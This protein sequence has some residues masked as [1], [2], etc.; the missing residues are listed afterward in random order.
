[1]SSKILIAALL[2]V[3]TVAVAE[4]IHFHSPSVIQ[5]G[6]IEMQL[7]PGYFLPEEDWLKLDTEIKRLQDIDT[8]LTAE[9]DVLK[10]EV[11]KAPNLAAIG[12]VIG[13]AVL[14]GGGAVFLLTR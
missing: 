1:M 12:L 6:D 5:S 10:K 7:P 4:P 13:V 9:N 14:V 3:S 11:D 2:L 8:R